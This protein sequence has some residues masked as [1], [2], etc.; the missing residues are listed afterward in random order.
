MGPPPRGAR[1]GASECFCFFL[2]LSLS[3]PPPVL[4]LSS[5]RSPFVLRPFLANSLRICG[6]CGTLTQT[7]REHS[8]CTRR[9][10]VCE[11]PKESRRGQHK[12]GARA[13]RVEALAAAF[14]ITGFDEYAER[15]LSGFGWGASFWK[16]NKSLI[17]QYRQCNTAQEVSRKQDEIIAQLDASWAQSRKER[18][19]FYSSPVPA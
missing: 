9:G 15:L 10:L 16:V 12:R 17:E 7:A 5:S 11:Y 13:A 1:S 6:W 18:G 14:Y 3:L 2:C 4:L 19:T 8:Q